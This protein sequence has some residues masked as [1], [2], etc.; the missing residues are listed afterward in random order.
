MAGWFAAARFGLF[1]HWDHASRQGL[2]LSW[3]LVGGLFALPKCQS[4]SVAEYHASAVDFDPHD[5]DARELART[6]RA[7]GM[8]YAVFTAKHHA[9]Y[10]STRR[11]GP[12][13]P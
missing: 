9:G 11:S 2:E 6:A 5:W 1:V 8:Q 3:P 13:T 7:A 12:S 4:V 10:A